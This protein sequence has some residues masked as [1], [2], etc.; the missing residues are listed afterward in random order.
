MLFDNATDDRTALSRTGHAAAKVH[1]KRTRPMNA[2]R[3]D[4]RALRTRKA[5]HGAL[6]ALILRKGYEAL[7]V[8]D[9]I[10]EADVGRST[11]YAHFTGKDHLLRAGF[12]AFRKELAASLPPP[13]GPAAEPDEALAEAGLALYAHAG[14]YRHVYEALIGGRGGVVVD[15]EF[16]RIV[17]DIMRD[18]LA[19]LPAGGDV[20]APLR[21]EFT[22]AT[23]LTVLEW[24]FSRKSPP[25]AEALNAMFLRLSGGGLRG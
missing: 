15:R 19:P 8:Q 9:I 13:P 22:V 4:R 10:D 24:S 17:T 25:S 20:P 1:E 18:R 5:L 14:Q 2:I 3:E 12:D 23:F 21:L 7:T 11:F 16:R 6:M